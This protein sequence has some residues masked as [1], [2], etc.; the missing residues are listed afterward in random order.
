MNYLLEK[1]IKLRCSVFNCLCV[2]KHCFTS[3]K[4]YFL[5]F[6]TFGEYIQPPS[7]HCTCGH[8]VTSTVLGGDQP[9]LIVGDKM[10]HMSLLTMPRYGRHW[11]GAK[12]SSHSSRVNFG[13]KVFRVSSQLDRQAGLQG[14]SPDLSRHVDF[15]RSLGTVYSM[16]PSLAP[17]PLGGSERHGEGRKKC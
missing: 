1:E 11:E 16:N 14:W 5:H 17:K 9:S 8:A 13:A 12:K 3:C 6:C 10:R 7:G 15:S 2:P 4:V